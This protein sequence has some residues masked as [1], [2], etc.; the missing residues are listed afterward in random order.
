MERDLGRLRNLSRTEYTLQ[1]TNPIH[2]GAE[3][4]PDH[5]VDLHHSSRGR[6]RAR[7]TSYQERRYYPRTRRRFDQQWL[8]DGAPSP[9]PA[10]LLLLLLFSFSLASML[11]RQ[12]FDRSANRIQNESLE[13]THRLPA[14]DW[15]RTADS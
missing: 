9:D 1:M 5:I 11:A 2:S 6:W 15:R 14:A 4:R 7:D 8:D 3:L 10:F 12:A 13:N